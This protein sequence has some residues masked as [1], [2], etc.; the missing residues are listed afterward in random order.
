MV[1]CHKHCHSQRFGL[2]NLFDRRN[3]VVA[4]DDRIHTVRMR[5]INQMTADSITVPHPVRNLCADNTAAPLDPA[6][7]NIRSHHPVDIIIPDNPHTGPLP[8]LSGQ[9]SG[10]KIPVL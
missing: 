6:A 10:Q 3:T 7:E 8:D 5:Q 4:G 2:R 9:N 1:I